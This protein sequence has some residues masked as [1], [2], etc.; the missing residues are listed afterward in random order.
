[1]RSFI[2]PRKKKL[3]DEMSLLWLVFIIVV[4]AGLIIF[5]IV[6]HYKSSFYIKMLDS[7]GKENSA[8][9]K[10]VQDLQQ[11]I[12]L[13][14][15]QGK[16]A[17]EVNTS[18]TALKE[19]MQ[20]LFDLIPDQITLTKVVMKRKALYLKGYTHSKESYTLLLEPPLKSIFTQ[21]KVKFYRDAQGRLV[22]ESLNTMEE[23]SGELMTDANT[24]K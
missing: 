9:I 13:V 2:K 10:T 5:G 6:L 14:T 23:N 12:A 1:M 22:F 15:A 18:N 4:A 3:L 21:S 19:S 16:L 24:S 20:N 8:Q 7:L 17:Q 11:K